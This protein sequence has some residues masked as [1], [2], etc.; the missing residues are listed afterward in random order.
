MS[1]QL[2]EHIEKDG[3]RLRGLA[4]SR[5]DGFSDAVFAFA[6]TLLVVSL[7]VPKTFA[8][9]QESL[10][11]FVP[12]AI[13]FYLLMQVWLAHYQYFRRFG[14][15]DEW[16][17]RLNSMLLFVVL[18]YVY[19]LKF[20]FSFITDLM[21]GLP[22]HAFDNDGQLRQLM[23][24]YGVGY[25]AIHFLVAALYCNGFRQRKHLELNDLEVRLARG[26][27]TRSA[28]IGA[29]GV[30]ACLVA[31]ILPAN[32][33]GS[34]GYTYLLVWLFLRLHDWRTRKLVKKQ[35]AL[36]ELTPSSH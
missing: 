4:S 33:A 13:V 2:Q 22:Q 8:Q 5:I 30:L 12:F 36:H 32:L 16:T 31:F 1:L 24:L 26:Y 3:F 9:L 28:G 19:P 15:H 17:I 7:E 35:T 18:F 14:T 23:M 25:A 20:L 34:S 10:R 29:I 11:G 21:M 6:L 27:I